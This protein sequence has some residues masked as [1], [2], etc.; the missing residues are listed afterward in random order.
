MPP[1]PPNKPP[2]GF[3]PCAIQ[4]R[5]M[6]HLF[7]QSF[8]NTVTVF[9]SFWS[10]ANPVTFCNIQH[11]RSR[12]N[13]TK[14]DHKILL[15]G[16]TVGIERYYQPQCCPQGSQS[17]APSGPRTRTNFPGLFKTS[18]PLPPLSPTVMTQ[19]PTSLEKRTEVSWRQLIITLTSSSPTTFSLHIPNSKSPYAALEVSPSSAKL[20]ASVPPASSVILLHNHSVCL[21][22]LPLLLLYSNFT[23]HGKKQLPFI[24][25]HPL[26]APC[27]LCISTISYS[28]FSTVWFRSYTQ[29]P[30]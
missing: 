2:L 5:S 1:V 11:P 20:V 12:L 16:A 15:T 26:K 18:L 10:F 21:Q 24:L 27:L 4:P 14:E 28:F 30:L 17:A 29:R 19:P 9:D 13:M 23:S 7:H 8:T 25:Y 6:V 22:Y 3:P